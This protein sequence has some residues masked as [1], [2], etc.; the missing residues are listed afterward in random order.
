MLKALGTRS[1]YSATSVDQL[2]HQ[3]VANQMFGHQLL[4]PIPD[5]DRTS[6]LL[7]RRRQPDGLQRL[8]DD[9]AGLPDPDPRP[10]GA[11]RP[12]GRARPAA[13]R[14]RQGRDRAPLRPS[15]HRR[16]AA[17]G[18]AARAVRGGADARRRPGPRALEHGRAAA[19]AVH[20]RARRGAHRRPGRRRSATLARDLAGAERGVVYGRIGVSTHEFG[21]VC[22]W[23]ITC[24]NALT[25]QPRRGRRGDVHLAGHRHRRDPAWSAPATSRRRHQPG[26]RPPGDRRRAARLGAARGDRDPGRRARSAACSPWPATRCCPRRTAAGSPTSIAGLDFVVAIDIY[27]NETTR[28]ADVILPPTTALE[29]DHYDLVFHALAVRN[30]ARFTPAV[31]RQGPAAPATTGRSTATSPGARW[32]GW[33]ASSRWRQR[34]HAA[35]AAR[36]EPR[37]AGR[38][39]A[40]TRPLG[41]HPAA[42]ARHPEGVDLGPLRA[43]QLPGRLQTRDGLVDLAP[44]AGRRRPGAARPPSRRRTPTA[45]C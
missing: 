8:A 27:V 37:P 15:G 31:L 44:D 38:P 22:Q 40:A 32:P 17:A 6:Y 13:H 18:D 23:A 16:L 35:G 33:A 12:H 9:R 5:L 21:S 19:T 43:G 36:L 2:P 26:A 14:D 39:A 11:R 3:L 34:L 25:G 30:T 1:R 7:V 24:L 29:R 4:L 42:A 41:S 45:C 10:Q 28:Q 20:P